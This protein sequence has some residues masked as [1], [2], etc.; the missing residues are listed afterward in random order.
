[1]AK[2][3]N[4]KLWI[5]AIVIIVIVLFAQPGGI[6]NTSKN[7]Q[8]VIDTVK[9]TVSGGGGSTNAKL[10][11]AKTDFLSVRLYDK[12]GK[13]ITSPE[14]FSTVVVGGVTTKNVYYMDYTV[15]VDASTSGTDITCSLTSVGPAGSAFDIT[16]TCG[17]G[18]VSTM[19]NQGQLNIIAGTK[20]T[21]T[22]AKIPLPGGAGCTL[23][24][25][26]TLV[27][28]VACTYFDGTSQVAVSGSPKT[29]SFGPITISEAGAAGY[30]VTVSNGGIPTSFCGDGVCDSPMEN[31]VS[32]TSDCS[33]VSNIKFRAS[34]LSY[35]S[36]SA[37]GYYGGTCG[38]TLTAY[39]YNSTGCFM[40][41]AVPDT[42]AADCTA[43][44]SRTGYTKLSTGVVLP[45]NTNWGTKNLGTLA[46]TG[47]LFQGAGVTAGYESTTQML[48]AFK[49]VGTSGP[50]GSG[51]S[52]YWGY[53]NYTSN[54]VW[55]KSI[56]TAK[57][58]TQAG[59]FDFAKE[60][61]CP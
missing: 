39:G 13:L 20:E 41:G 55:T 1:M 58:T 34:D 37:I 27:A 61:T 52:G 60:K 17:D 16:K 43:F 46:T 38:N 22:S 7:V 8:K 10:G 57:V 53:V 48:M 35:V 3:K 14:T 15:M 19:P 24:G 42:N 45:G 33:P 21:W 30:T 28:V 12:N 51:Y 18:G 36:G 49:Q 9:N 5:I 2:K 32:C 44:A 47:C 56:F 31:S 23:N 6:S 40:T 4:N 54:S 29:G 59:G 11:N 26:Y 25:A 50:C